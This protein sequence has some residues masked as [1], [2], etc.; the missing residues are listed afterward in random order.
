MDLIQHKYIGIRGVKLHI[1]EVGS[2]LKSDSWFC[3]ILTL[4]VLS[5]SLHQKTIFLFAGSSVLVFIHGL[6]EIWYSWRHQMAAVAN[7][8][9]RAIAPDLRG[10]GLSGH[11]PELEKASFNDSVQDTI[12]ILDYFRID[13]VKL[14]S[15]YDISFLASSIPSFAV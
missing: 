1:A 7:A 4:L 13:K 15:I 2:G 12:A 11:H 3:L 8:G 6:P 10:Y 5:F 9:Y 14:A